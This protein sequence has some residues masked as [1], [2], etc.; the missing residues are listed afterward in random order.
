MPGI[1][2]GANDST[3]KG[4]SNS[5]GA[6][7]ALSVPDLGPKIKRRTLLL[8]PL[9]AF[10]LLASLHAGHCSQP[11]LFRVEVLTQTPVLWGTGELLSGPKRVS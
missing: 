10:G 7:Y 5:L 2:Q 1:E 11:G 9:A 8:C 3:T 4:I 6:C